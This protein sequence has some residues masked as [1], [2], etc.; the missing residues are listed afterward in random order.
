MEWVMLFRKL[1]VA[2][3]AIMLGACGG[4]SVDTGS[5]PD[6]SNRKAILIGVDGVQY[7]RL[8][9]LG[10]PNIQRLN[11]SPAYAGGIVGTPSEQATSSGPSWSTILTGVWVDR[12]SIVANQSGV[13]RPGTHSV[14][15]RLNDA[16]PEMTMASVSNWHPINTQYL[17]HER[18]DLDL[19]VSNVSDDVVVEQATQFIASGG[20]FVFTHLDTPDKVGHASCAGADYDTALLE[21]DARVGQLLDAVEKD[22]A[23]TGADWLIIVTTDH[24]RDDRGCDHGA[25]TRI[26]KTSFVAMNKPGN[27]EFQSVEAG[28]PDDSFEGLYGAVSLASVTPTIFAHLGVT[29]DPAWHL[30]GPPLIGELGIRKLMRADARSLT[31]ISESEAD[32]VILKDGKQVGNVLAKNGIWQTDQDRLDS[33][34]YSVLV[35][36]TAISIE[37]GRAP[38]LMV[39]AAFAHSASGGSFFRNNKTFIRSNMDTDIPTYSPPMTVTEET[40][41]GLGA[42]A[43]RISAAVSVDGQFAFIFLS[44]SHFVKYDLIT[45]EALPNYPKRLN[46]IS[47]PGIGHYG[48]QIVAAMKGEGERVYFF[49]Q[50]ARFM[51]YDLAEKRPLS[52]RP[53]PID[54]TSWPGLSAHANKI[55]AA[56]RV[57]DDIGVFI[58][59]DQ[60]T[61]P[62]VFS[63]GTAADPIPSNHPLTSGVFVD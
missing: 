33:G 20:D 61:V 55:E 13:F 52:D 5:E 53:L 48:S 50:D 30:A 16:K 4:T 39:E 43:D 34:V 7:E 35:E 11:H 14:F 3:L 59:S 42:I 49:L 41:P 6:F 29:I 37:V 63:E 12:H 2:C 40:W 51:E 44:D 31:W 17:A 22:Q 19:I 8:I 36:Q 25:Q 28:V 10:A 23:E 38:S 57:S 60:S 15:H 21:T 9:E 58:L 45:G 32:A 24:G 27:A 1:S 46:P 26:E 62:F 56:L 47:W 18:G 54:D